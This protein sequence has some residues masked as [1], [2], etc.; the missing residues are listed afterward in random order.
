MRHVREAIA[1]TPDIARNL[2]ALGDGSIEGLKGHHVTEAARAGDVVAL[3]ALVVLHQLFQH[4]KLQ[5]Y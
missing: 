4:A 2:L 5:A 3:A 1:A